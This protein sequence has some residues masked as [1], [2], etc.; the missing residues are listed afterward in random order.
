MSAFRPGR[1]GEADETR[2]SGAGEEGWP[3]AS[4][5]ESLLGDGSLVSA[6]PGASQAP[7]SGRDSST[8]RASSRRETPSL[9]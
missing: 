6:R 3:A 5:R 7:Q 2:L 1:G 8:R 9:P 4:L